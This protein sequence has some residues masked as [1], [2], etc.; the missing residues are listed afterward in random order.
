M[1]GKR[2]RD[3]SVVSRST[4]VDEEEKPPTTTDASAHDVFRKFFESRFLPVELRSA[5]VSHDTEEP[6]GEDDENDSEES[7]SGSEW[8][9]ISEPEDKGNTVEVVEHTDS[10]AKADDVVDKKARKAFMVST[11]HQ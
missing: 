4:T 2:K 6:E 5:P 1:V 7:E 10:T 11:C 9:G 3:T 8:S